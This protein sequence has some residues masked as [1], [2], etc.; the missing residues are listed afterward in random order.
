MEQLRAVD[1]LRDC[2]E[3]QLGE[4]ARL[5]ERIQVGEGEVLAREGRIGREFFLIL[6]GTVAVTQKGRRVNTLG[7]GDFFGELAALNP[8]PRTA[9]V[10]AL[11]ELDVL[12]IGPRELTSM[13][14]IPGFRDALL[15]SMAGRLRTMD[16]RLAA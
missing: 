10:T 2:T 3:A 1:Q 9:T 6:S 12:I 8:G 4:V 11:S 15:R 14:D 13:A 16:A 5:A 7:P